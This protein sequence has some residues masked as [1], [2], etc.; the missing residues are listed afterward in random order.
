MG[1]GDLWEVRRWLIGWGA[2]A[3]VLEPLELAREVED[4]ARRILAKQC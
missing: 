2:D 4:H 1:V 3:E